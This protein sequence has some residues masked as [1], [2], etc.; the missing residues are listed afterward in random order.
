M[1]FQVDAFNSFQSLI[2]DLKQ[3]SV[4][5]FFA[6]DLNYPLP[7]LVGDTIHVVGAKHHV[8][9]SYEVVHAALKLRN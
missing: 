7:W 3:E 9:A 4:F 2:A 1:L 5:V 8:A 6:V